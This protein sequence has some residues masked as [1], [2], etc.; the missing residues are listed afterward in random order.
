MKAIWIADQFKIAAYEIRL[1]KAV[2]PK[3]TWLKITR[4]L[5]EQLNKLMEICRNHTRRVVAP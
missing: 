1:G 2:Q 3:N 4:A 5:Y